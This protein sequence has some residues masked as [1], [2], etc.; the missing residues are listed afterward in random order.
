MGET[1]LVNSRSSSAARSA[2]ATASTRA[3]A[4]AAAPARRSR[5]SSEMAFSV[6]SRSARRCSDA[7]RSRA[8][9]RLRELGAE[10][11]DLRL[12]RPV[13]DLEEH[14]PL[15]DQAAFLER[16]PGD[17]A[18]DARPDRDRLHGLEPAGELVPLGDVARDGGAR[19]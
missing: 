16:D 11:R 14:L 9:R 19:R 6:D 2:A 12:E 18:R 13:V 5:S 3:A 10:P 15:P 4:S 17:Q 8:A 7:A 1:T